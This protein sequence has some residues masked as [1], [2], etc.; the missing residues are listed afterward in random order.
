MARFVWRLF[1]LIMTAP[2]VTAS[3]VPSPS[4]A[5]NPSTPSSG[6]EVEPNA[7]CSSG[8][9]DKTEVMPFQLGDGEEEEASSFVPTSIAGSRVG[10]PVRW[11]LKY[12]GD[13]AEDGC[14]RVVGKGNFGKTGP[15]VVFCAFSLCFRVM[16]MV[17]EKAFNRLT[18]FPCFNFIRLRCVD[19]ERHG[20]FFNRSHSMH[21]SLL[22]TTVGAA[23]RIAFRRHSSVKDAGTLQKNACQHRSHRAM[24]LALCCLLF[25]SIENSQGGRYLQQD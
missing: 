17:L 18:F 14:G 9:N 24:P 10:R 16:C 19:R 12:L 1:Q 20:F 25:V 11:S 13:N 8:G 7:S 4:S 6:G 21:P 22:L 23:P 5:T 2:H 3:G 15:S